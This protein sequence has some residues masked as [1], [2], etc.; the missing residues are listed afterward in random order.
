MRSL[1]TRVERI[2]QKIRISDKSNEVRTIVLKGVYSRRGGLNDIP[3]EPPEEWLT[4]KEQLK[5]EPIGG[6]RFIYLD[7]DEELR[8]RSVQ[9]EATRGQEGRELPKKTN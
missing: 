5:N 1:Y 3:Q 7:P 9:K 4:Y 6:F 8:A 2:E